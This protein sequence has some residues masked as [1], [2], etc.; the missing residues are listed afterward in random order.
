MKKEILKFVVLL[1]VAIGA[2]PA[3]SA[4]YQWSK[5]AGNNSNA[6]P[7]INWA[8]GMSPSTVNDSARAMMA[9]AAEY[10]DDIS[11][12]LTTAGTSTAY[13]VATNQGFNATPNDGQ[14]LAVTPHV[15][16]GGSSTL[17]ADGG[18]AFPIQSSAGTAISAGTLL[19]GTPYTLKFS[20][21]ASA[22]VLR[23]FYGNSSIPLGGILWST[24][25]TAP[26][27]DF[28]A[29]SGQC[30][31]TTTYATYWVAMGSPA[32]GS[33]PGGQFAIIDMRG[34]VAAA[35]DTL[36]AVAANRLTTSANGCG[37]AMTT[38]GATCA[39]G[40]ES[41]TLTIAQIP[42]HTHANVLVD[43]GH[44]HNYTGPGFTDATAAGLTRPGS[45]LWG[46]A[47]I[48]TT[49]LAGTNMTLNNAA[50]GGGGAHP[51]VMP[52]IGLIPYLR[53]L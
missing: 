22:W 42:S 2:A 29:P 45:T 20:A 49:T 26:N 10:R 13:T 44:T 9:R 11:G 32:S 6:D 8:E 51:I 15:T 41:Q 34:R 43:P 23:D 31:S 33:C 27:S 14:L 35:L 16:N 28:V 47:A 18:N 46:A 25:P 40:G 36:N 12:L 48:A 7:S 21:S 17:T 3:Y 50:A 4:F 37:T 38:V 19:S 1:A 30:I 39:N 5:V 53:I 52:T 24:M